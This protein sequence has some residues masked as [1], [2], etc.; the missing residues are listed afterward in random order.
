MPRQK[1]APTEKADLATLNLKVPQ[2]RTACLSMKTLLHHLPF[3]SEHGCLPIHNGGAQTH[4]H[5]HT[6][7]HTEFQLHIQ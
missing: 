6:H 4:S 2:M 5:T 1:L 3:S 7:T